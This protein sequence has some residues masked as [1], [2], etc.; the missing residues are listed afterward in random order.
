MIAFIHGDL[1][2]SKTE[3]IAQGVAEGNQ[4]G[5]GTGLALEISKRWTEVQAAFKRHTRGGRFKGGDIWVSAPTDLRPDIIYLATQ[6]DMYHATVPFLRKA[7]RKMVKWANN[8]R[9]KSIG[10]PKVG[11]GLGKLSWENIVKPLFKEHLTESP[12]R[13]IVFE[14]TPQD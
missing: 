1:L 2:T 8:N 13:F 5:L 4:E 14:R 11:A 6:P 3:Y 12:C 10:L 9:I 7:V